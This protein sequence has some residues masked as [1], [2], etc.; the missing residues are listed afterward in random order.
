MR[1]VELLSE[2]QQK[3]LNTMICEY[4]TAESKTEQKPAETRMSQVFVDEK[5]SPFQIWMNQIEESDL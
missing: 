4:M 1:K 2:E 3:T 5:M